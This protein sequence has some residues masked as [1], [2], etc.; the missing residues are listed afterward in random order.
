MRYGHRW[1][2][3]G[4][5]RPLALRAITIAYLFLKG[6]T[7]LLHLRPQRRRRFLVIV[8]T[9]FLALAALLANG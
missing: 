9:L 1:T 4:R 5:L 6:L 3:I 2:A 7:Q 8:M